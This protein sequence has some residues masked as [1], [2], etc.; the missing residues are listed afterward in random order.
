MHSL[1][2][3]PQ[4]I[5]ETEA[6]D[7]FSVSGEGTEVFAIKPKQIPFNSHSKK[8][9]KKSLYFKQSRLHPLQDPR[10]TPFYNL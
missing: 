10:S 6:H 7:N 3:A 9:N 2:K 4:H 1:K 5:L 8:L